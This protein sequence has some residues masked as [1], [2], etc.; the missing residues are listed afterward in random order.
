MIRVIENLFQV[1]FLNMLGIDLNRNFPT[2]F[3]F[4]NSTTI[5]NIYPGTSPISDPFTRC[6]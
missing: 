3:N 1:T 5:S 6:L 2:E 4:Y